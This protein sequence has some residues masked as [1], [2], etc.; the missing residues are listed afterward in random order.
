MPPL[1]LPRASLPPLAPLA[2]PRQQLVHSFATPPNSARG[3]SG[4]GG[5]GGGGSGGELGGGN[6]SGLQDASDGSVLLLR[7]AC[8]ALEPLARNRDNRP[9][10]RAKGRPR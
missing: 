1:V 9:A 10:L 5:S 4:G 2:A 7:S 3:G 8:R 6:Y